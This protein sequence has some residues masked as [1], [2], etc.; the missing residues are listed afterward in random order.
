[1]SHQ[2]TLTSSDLAKHNSQDS[3]SICVRGRGSD[4]NMEFEELLASVSDSG[5]FGLL[6]PSLSLQPL[7]IDT[8]TEGEE[9]SE[10]QVQPKTD[11][12][13]GRGQ[14]IGKRRP[15]HEPSSQAADKRCFNGLCNVVARGDRQRLV[16]IRY[17]GEQNAYCDMCAEAI[18]HKWTCPCCNAIYTDIS[19]CAQKDVLTWIECDNPRCKRWT[20][21]ECEETSRGIDIR[22]SLSDPTFKFYCG[23]CAESNGGC[24]VELNSP[25]T[26]ARKKMPS[27]SCKVE[28]VPYGAF[29]GDKSRFEEF[30]S[31][32]NK[33]QLYTSAPYTYLFSEQY[34]TMDR[35]C[36]LSRLLGDDRR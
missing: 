5:M 29:Q 13:I 9:T 2:S 20:H 23:D 28:S 3:P 32:E 19:H 26:V 7:T 35:L 10:T 27:P 34:Q 24:E 6:I 30:M 12:G 21:M 36:A 8:H 4:M 16:K 17:L 1:M 11:I 33:Y 22:R 25:L 15:I 18:R 14:L 31:V